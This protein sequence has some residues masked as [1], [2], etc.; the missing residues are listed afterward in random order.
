MKIW[1]PIVMIIG[2]LG[3]LIGVSVY[4]MGYPEVQVAE[5]LAPEGSEFSGRQVKLQGRIAAIHSEFGIIHF[6][7]S[8][9]KDP[10]QVVSVKVDGLRPDLFKV[11]NDVAVDG[12]YDR[13]Q[14]EMAGT[15][16]YTK[17][18]S[19]YEASKGESMNYEAA[20]ETAAAGADPE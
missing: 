5:L 15:K 19:K 16:I 9:K 11:G 10:S 4:S 12:V 14:G 8:D 20:P 13:A 7:V 18:P 2:A 6:D 1:I 17:C 3:T